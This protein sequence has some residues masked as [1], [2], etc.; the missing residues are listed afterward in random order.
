[1]SLVLATHPESMCTATSESM[2]VA[3]LEA[4]L[5][6][7]TSLTAL[8]VQYHADCDSKICVDSLFNNKHSKICNNSNAMKVL[9][10]HVLGNI[11]YINVNEHARN[12]VEKTMDVVTTFNHPLVMQLL[13]SRPAVTRCIIQNLDTTELE[14]LVAF[15]FDEEFGYWN[16]PLRL[17]IKWAL[18]IWRKRR[19]AKYGY[20]RHG[21]GDAINDGDDEVPYW[22]WNQGL[23]VPPG[24]R[25]KLQVMIL[26]H[27]LDHGEDSVIP[28]SSIDK[29]N[30]LIRSNRIRQEMKKIM[31]E[32][33]ESI[34]PPDLQLHGHKL[35]LGHRLDH[36]NDVAC[37]PAKL[38]RTIHGLL[39][40]NKKRHEL[41]E[42]ET[43]ET[44]VTVPPTLRLH[45]ECLLLD[46]RLDCGEDAQVPEKL[47][48][49]IISLLRVLLY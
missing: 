25:R 3:S 2:Q 41:K 48:R 31:E 45:I 16:F 27:R 6:R 12:M 46:H 43:W 17:Y 39:H 44:D 22:V 28:Q 15:V 20:S 42:Y 18:K 10:Q 5:E 11:M 8:L 19:D 7:D 13:K 40:D 47:R 38:R 21:P 30:G 34:V 36:G 32:L 24:L 26:N 9:T 23:A 33:Q 14:K 49:K 29:M 1:M 35:L 37:I 4:A